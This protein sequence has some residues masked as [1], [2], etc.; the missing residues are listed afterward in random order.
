MEH[1]R[2]SYGARTGTP[3]VWGQRPG[4]SKYLG[5][6]CQGSRGWAGSLRPVPGYRDEESRPMPERRGHRALTGSLGLTSP[7]Q[8]WQKNRCAATAAP[9][10]APAAEASA[11]FLFRRGRPR[12]QPAGRS[13]GRYLPAAVAA[14]AV[15]AAASSVL[16][17]APEPA[18][19]T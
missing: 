9:A 10:P 2:G 1:A 6:R 3:G 4:G 13:P 14:S 16:P 11:I 12:G 15:A 18:R 17:A 7:L 8:K 5:D 19:V